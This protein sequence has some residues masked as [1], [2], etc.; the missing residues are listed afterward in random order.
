MALPKR[1]LPA[2]Y[3]WNGTVSNDQCGVYAAFQLDDQ[4]AL[5]LFISLFFF[6]SNFLYVVHLFDE[7]L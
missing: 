3:L 7:V 6:P 4:C 5:F 2:T 1:Y